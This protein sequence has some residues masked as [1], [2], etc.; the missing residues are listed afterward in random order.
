M[1]M[2]VPSG[3]LHAIFYP[4]DSIVFLGHFLCKYCI[5]LQL[6][7]AE[8]QNRIEVP[9]EE[10]FPAFEALHWLAAQ[11]LVDEWDTISPSVRPTWLRKGI[12]ALHSAL[13]DWVDDDDKIIPEMGFHRFSIVTKLERLLPVPESINAVPSDSGKGI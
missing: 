3:W 9:F 6:K 11:V 2:I 4:L 8:I 13:A 1:T 12:V 10:R 7:V 5:D